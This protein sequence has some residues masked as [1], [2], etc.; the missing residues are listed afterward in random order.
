MDYMLEN[1]PPLA[2]Y[3]AKFTIPFKHKKQQPIGVKLERVINNQQIDNDPTASISF[4]WRNNA[5][6]F[7]LC[8]FSSMLFL[9][10]K[11]L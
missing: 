6:N 5:L 10:V 7:A 11:T 2:V 3:N 8:V 9:T 4:V 1:N